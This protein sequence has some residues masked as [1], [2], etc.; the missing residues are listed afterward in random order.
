MA[1]HIPLR[2]CIATGVKKPKKELVRLV[3]LESGQVTFDLTGKVR[4]RGASLDSNMAA[5]DLAIKKSAIE[6]AL[7]LEKKLTPDEI[8]DLRIQFENVLEEKNFRSGNKPVTVRVSRDAI[9]T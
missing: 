1:K 2:T 8:S 9:P 7:K 3:R 4:G 6:R 5:F